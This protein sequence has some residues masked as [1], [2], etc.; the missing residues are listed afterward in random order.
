MRAAQ[1]E[2]FAKDD[3][4]CASPP[5]LR[6]RRISELHLSMLPKVNKPVKVEPWIE[7]ID[8]PIHHGDVNFSFI[9]NYTTDA[10]DTSE[11]S[12][13]LV[14]VSL[15]ARAPIYVDVATTTTAAKSY[16]KDSK[17]DLNNRIFKSRD[18]D[19]LKKRRHK[20]G[21]FN[22]QHKKRQKPVNLKHSVDPYDSK[23]RSKG[24][25]RI[26]ETEGSDPLKKD[27]KTRLFAHLLSQDNGDI[28]SSTDGSGSADPVQKSGG[29]GQEEGRKDIHTQARPGLFYEAYVRTGRIDNQ[30]S[31]EDGV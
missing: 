23:T 11:D 19:K 10:E 21:Y 26:V 25:H 27:S 3:M 8:L 2:F 28:I 9:L 15:S 18:G 31:G 7:P 22:D 17:P 24:R 14:N 30:N 6:G 13:H 29:T 16:E 5:E 4:V 1:V 12:D 20:N